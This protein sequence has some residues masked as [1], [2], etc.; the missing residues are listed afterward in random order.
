MEL[1]VAP[2]Q[3]DDQLRLSFTLGL[4]PSAAVSTYFDWLGNLV[5]VFSTTP[6]HKDVQIVASS[7]VETHRPVLDM[8][9]LPDVWPV[10]ILDYA[11]YDYLQF[12]GPITD[13][14]DLRRV[15]AQLYPLPGMPLGTLMM[16]VLRLI[17]T[18]FTY[19][20]G[21]TTASTPVTDVLTHRRGVCQD[22]THL[23]IAMSRAMG[24]PARY[25][26]GIIHSG[27]SALRGAAQTHAWC[28]VYFPSTGWIGFDPTNNAPVD[29]RF[30]IVAVG[31]DYR[32]VP[33]NRGVYKGKAKESMQVAV[34]TEKLAH[35]PNHLAGER[36]QML[37][38]PM[39]PESRSMA[40]AHMRQLEEQQQQQ[41]Q[42]KQ[43]QQQ[44]QQQQ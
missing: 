34:T 7:I 19:E 14:D 20:K 37:R 23:M 11:Y 1:R 32:D 17:H 43:Y 39:Y 12:G 3:A 31:R 21:V 16:Q 40:P 30:V 27:N 2:R 36:I 25:V 29:D 24:I 9:A 33:P 26:S 15:V 13:S 41:Q 6:M 5:H 42:E 18:G 44:Q 22:F 10:P 4:G 38:T 8:P 35:V 28:E